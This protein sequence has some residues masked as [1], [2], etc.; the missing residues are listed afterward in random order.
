MH[1]AGLAPRACVRSALLAFIP[2]IAIAPYGLAQAEREGP[3][4]PPEVGAVARRA[5]IHLDGRLDEPGLG[6]GACDAHV[7]DF[8][9]NR[10]LDAL[11]DADADDIFLVKVSYW[12]QL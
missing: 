12:F 11:L 7:G 2:L 5:A 8:D 6:G 10:D 1:Q 9:L 4:P 3:P